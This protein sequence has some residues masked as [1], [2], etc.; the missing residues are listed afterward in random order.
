MAEAGRIFIRQAPLCQCHLAF[1]QQ[2][3]NF[4]LFL[5]KFSYPQ[6]TNLLQLFESL[7]LLYKEAINQL[8]ILFQRDEYLKKRP[9]CH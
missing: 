6:L 4:P 7:M 8:Y 9:L 3:P 2:S 5:L 1:D